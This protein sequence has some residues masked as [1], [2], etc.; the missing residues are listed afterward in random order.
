MPKIIDHDKYRKELAEKAV[1]IFRERGYSGLG[2]RKI[3]QELGISKSAL[4]HY[5]PSK[6]ALFFSCTKLVMSFD[7]LD[8]QRETF[9][10]M[11]K[12]ERIKGLISIFKTLEE[13]F[14][15]ELSLIIDYI[16][17][18]SPN[19]IASDKNMQVFNQNY[20]KMVSS[21]VD[22]KQ[23]PFV[24]CVMNGVLLQRLFDGQG[25]SFQEIEEKLL[26]FCDLG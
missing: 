17:W 3:A 9:Q 2:M 10:K 13:E 7:H 18:L 21:F 4:Y 1:T 14:K 19:Q 15:G 25:Y 16:R 23:A 20:L 8:L 26:P 6:D 12:Q 11:G 24:L 22:Q 5:F